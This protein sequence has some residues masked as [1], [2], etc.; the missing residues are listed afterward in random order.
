MLFPFYWYQLLK[1]VQTHGTIEKFDLIFHRTGPFA[2][3]PRGFAFVT[4][5]SSKD[6]SGAKTCLNG[7]LVG[8]KRLAVTWAHS[9]DLDS[10]SQEKPKP[11]VSIPALALSKDTKKTDRM[12]QIQ[13]I[14]AKLQLMKQKEDE[15]K[16]N[17]SIA[18]KTPVIQQFQ[19]N[20]ERVGSKTQQFF[21]FHNRSKK[22]Y[23]RKA[24][25]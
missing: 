10:G 24:K 15:L 13:A 20:K 14:E 2:G 1:L 5:N 6:A 16:I 22:P 17:D 19:F 23:T 3:L 4:Y 12:S 11:S 8:Q 9:A 7:K 25:Q 21:K 18:T